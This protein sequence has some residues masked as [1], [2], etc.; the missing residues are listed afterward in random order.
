ME[1]ASGSGVFVCLQLIKSDLPGWLWGRSEAAEAVRRPPRSGYDW[2]AWKCPKVLKAAKKSNQAER[3]YD[4]WILFPEDKTLRNL[5]KNKIFWIS[6]SPG[7]SPALQETKST[8]NV[9]VYSSQGS[10][11][12][13]SVLSNVFPVERPKIFPQQRKSCLF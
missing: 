12:L 4:E 7:L 13:Q 11:C 9:I 2:P 10:S 3:I 6:G 5:F 1:T 8:G